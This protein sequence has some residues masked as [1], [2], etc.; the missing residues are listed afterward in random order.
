VIPTKTSKLV[1]QS[2]SREGSCSRS[3]ARHVSS[4][5]FLVTGFQLY[6]EAR[7]LSRLMCWLIL[8][9]HL[10]FTVSVEWLTPRI[11]CSQRR[12]Q[13]RCTDSDIRMRRSLVDGPHLITLSS[14][15]SGR[16]M[17]PH[18]RISPRCMAGHGPK[19]VGHVCH[20]RFQIVEIMMLSQSISMCSDSGASLQL[21]QCALWAYW[22]MSFQKSPIRNAP[23]RAL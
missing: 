11:V 20:A 9:R 5:S 7:C 2:S 6:M 13:M 4:T 8:L 14:F 19:D 17:L 10:D 18:P 1:I 23:C 22:G 3:M 16:A 15:W 21:E 12:T